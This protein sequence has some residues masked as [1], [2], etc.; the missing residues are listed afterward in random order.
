MAEKLE[1]ARERLEQRVSVNQLF[2][3]DEMIHVIRETQDKDYKG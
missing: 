3:Q 1:W 2:G